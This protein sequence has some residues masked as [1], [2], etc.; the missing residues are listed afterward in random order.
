MGL[1]CNLNF[2][3]PPRDGE[4]AALPHRVTHGQSHPMTWRLPLALSED[5]LGVAITKTRQNPS[6]RASLLLRF[7]WKITAVK[8]EPCRAD[9]SQDRLSACLLC[10]CPSPCPEP[11]SPEPYT[12]VAS[13][14]ASRGAHAWL[15][16]MQ[17][18]PW[19]LKNLS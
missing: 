7:G 4:A 12:E 8:T 2:P 3:K 10:L 14:G 13:L 19:L 5:R 18:L 9:H 17:V 11:T 16:S 1:W 15:W 6:I